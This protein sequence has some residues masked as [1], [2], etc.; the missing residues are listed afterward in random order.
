MYT[1][2]TSM[3]AVLVAAMLVGS[4]PAQAGIVG[5]EQMVSS[6]ARAASLGR[7][8]SVLA[9]EEVAAQLEAWG[10]APEAV[11]QRVAAL[12]D[13]ELQQLAAS[14]ETDPAGGVLAVIGVVFVVLIILHLTGF[15]RGFR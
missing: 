3:M 1:L 13:A 5:T 10:V 8:N 11:A 12:S 6:E 4:W 2:K 9:G 14:I 7:I 15:F